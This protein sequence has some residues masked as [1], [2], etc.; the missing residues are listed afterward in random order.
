M[1]TGDQSPLVLLNEAAEIDGGHAYVDGQPN[2]LFWKAR[3]ILNRRNGDIDEARNL[4]KKLYKLEE[5]KRVAP[6]TFAEALAT[7]AE[8]H[9]TTGNRSRADKVVALG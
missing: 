7:D 5:Q 4:I 8:W 6:W 9:L 1:A 2:G 3:Y